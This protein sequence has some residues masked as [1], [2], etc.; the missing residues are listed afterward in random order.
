MTRAAEP[1]LP[2]R[3]ERAIVLGLGK[4]TG[5]AVAGALSEAG[6]E[7]RVSEMSE[8]DHHRE[9]A[10]RLEAGARGRVEVFF[11]EPPFEWLEWADLIVPAPGVPPSHP[12][13]ARALRTE[14]TVWSELELGYRLSDRSLIAITGTNGKTTVTAMTEHV[15]RSCGVGATAAG[16]IGFPLVRAAR[17]L[18]E[19]EVIVCECSSAQLHFI[20]EF[21][22][23]IAAVL[24][25]GADHHDWHASQADYLSSKMR[26]T[27]RQLPGDVLVFRAEDEGC[28]AIA[29]ASAAGLF[30]FGADPVDRVRGAAQA[31]AGRDVPVVA[32]LSEGWLW[33][34]RGQDSERLIPAADIRLQGAHNVEN[35]LA[36]ALCAVAQGLPLEPVANALAGF[37]GLPHRT[38]EVRKLN[39]VAYIDDSKA[40]NPHATLRALED[41]KDVVLIAGGRAKGLDLS[42][43][44]AAAHK[45]RAVITMGEAS[46]ELAAVFSGTP[47]HRADSVEEAVQI[48]SSLAS[49]GDSVLLSPACSSLDQYT[50]YAERGDRFIAAVEAL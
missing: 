7:V 50:S 22:P 37:E 42:E 1:G 4:V 36:A 33:V 14:V 46:D 26:I 15:L 8:T 40:T 25:V 39:G 2:R 44:G 41:L 28:G 17:E 49:A 38:K 32:G 31:S 47:S 23:A 6:L 24:N 10:A 20:E 13:L 19:D 3:F 16:N 35:V 5:E 48:A 12:L 21:H 9:T 30:A 27:E 18:P 45:L 11:G 34:D 43:L 29:R